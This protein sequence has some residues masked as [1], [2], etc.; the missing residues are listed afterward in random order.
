MENL[1]DL[2]ARAR[3]ALAEIDLVLHVGNIGSLIFLKSLQDAFA[4]TFAV[5][6]RQDAEEVRRYLEEDKVVEFANRRIGMTFSSRGLEK[7]VKLPSLKRQSLKP[8]S[9]SER[10]LGKFDRVDCVVFGSPGNA[11]NHLYQGILVFNPGKIISE[12]G[13]KGSMGILEITERSMTGRILSV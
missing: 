8:N 6:G 12:D 2:P 4:L 5:Y 10:L 3:L 11:F 13:S 7:N 9:L 1:D